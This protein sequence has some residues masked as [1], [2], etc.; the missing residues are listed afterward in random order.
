MEI[1]EFN[2]YL[3]NLPRY[4]ENKNSSVIVTSRNLYVLNGG[5]DYNKQYCENNNIKV[6]NTH[7]MGGVIVN[8]EGDICIGNYQ[9]T[10][11]NFGEKFLQEFVCWLKEKKINCTISNNDV[12]VDGKFKVASYMSVFK[13]NCLYTAIHISVNMDINKIKLICLKEMIKVPKGLV[14]Y[15][16]KEKD[17]IDFSKSTITLLEG[18]E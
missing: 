7:S 5:N 18:R 12:L 9:P 10:H 1:I 13:N 6:L 17:V 16:I 4:M 14:D 2:D 3:R 8:F 11:N 15:G